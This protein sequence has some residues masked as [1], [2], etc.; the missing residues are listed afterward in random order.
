MKSIRKYFNEHICP[1]LVDDVIAAS[2]WLYFILLANPVIYVLYVIIGIFWMVVISTRY[3]T[4][5]LNATG[6]VVN[7]FLRPSSCHHSYADV[8]VKDDDGNLRMYAL[9]D[10]FRWH[11]K[12]DYY[13]MLLFKIEKG[14]RYQL[15]YVTDDDNIRYILSLEK[16]EN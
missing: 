6:T 12:D 10:L 13:R 8:L 2:R 1:K 16:L 4:V 15:L 3:Q 9:E 14:A 5:Q 11:F 7:F